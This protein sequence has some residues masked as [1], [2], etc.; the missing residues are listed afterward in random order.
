MK[1]E[2]L[3]LKIIAADYTY[4]DG[5]YHKDYAVAFEK[6]I[7][8]VGPAKEMMELYP[9]TEWIEKVS[10]SVLYPGFINTHVHLEFSSN[11]T[12]LNYGSYLPW[13]HSVI[14]DRNSLTETCTTEVMAEACQSMMQSG[15]STIGAIS[16]MGV[17]LDACVTTPQRVV[18]FNELIGSNPQTVD[19]LYSDFIQ[20][21]NSSAQYKDERVTPAI[22]IHSPY[23]VHPIVLKKAVAF[24]KEK[25]SL[26]SAHFLESEAERLWLTHSEGEFKSFFDTFFNQNRAT[27]TIEEFLSG[28]DGYPTHFVHCVHAQE[29]EL[30]KIAREKHTIAHCPR[31]NRLLG[32]G[33]LD[34]QRLERL[35]IPFSLATDG[36]SSNNSLNIFDEL[37]ATLMMHH[38]TNLHMLSLRLIRAITSDA[39]KILQLNCGQITKGYE[40]DF[41]LIQLAEKPKREED[42]ALWTIL[43]TEQ[44]TE[45]YI[46]GERYI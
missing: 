28:F 24:A 14:E 44:V 4:I 3:T 45:L 29:Q 42:I 19:V 39:A 9:D 12:T 11:K 1:I 5:R 17:D 6:K 38:E 13:L 15:V 8:A 33:K 27:T 46:E 7:I 20:R 35:G 25:Q 10:D 2:E 30:E 40:A 16:S 23:S 36:L 26:L 22:A 21:Y 37:R 43:H 32:C 31:S 41:A 18:F 34:L